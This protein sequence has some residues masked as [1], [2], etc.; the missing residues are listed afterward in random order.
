[1]K[2]HTPFFFAG[3]FNLVK[4][5]EGVRE[6]EKSNSKRDII[7]FRM[8]K[9]REKHSLEEFEIKFSIFFLL[10][11]SRFHHLHITHEKL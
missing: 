9:K 11:L 2:L 6:R 1:M 10:L 8:G 3:E 7:Q 5:S 4:V